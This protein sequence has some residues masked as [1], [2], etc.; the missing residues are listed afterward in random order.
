MNLVF[1][2]GMAGSGKSV[3]TS[4]YKDWLKL[5]DQNV[6]CVNL[7]PG[8]GAL[9]YNPDVDVRSYVS[10]EAIM[11]DYKLGPNGALVLAAD[12]IGDHVEEI[13]GEI[14]EA[15]AEIVLLDTPGQIELFAFRESGPYITKGLGDGPKALVY[16]FDAPF[17]RNPTNFVSN[18]FIAAAVYN[19]LF[20]P[21]V[22]ALTKIDLLQESEIERIQRWHEDPEVLQTALEAQIGREVSEIGKDLASAIWRTGI[23]YELVPL[24]AKSGNGIVELNATLTRILTG[25]EELKP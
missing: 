21:Q 23:V 13:R 14:D 15:G 10:L 6:I 1:L 18:M 8:A 5:G 9:P 7:D 22:Y 11:Q 25:G 3:L 24:S 19:R 17:C 2:V 4:V 16:L 20:Q 12:L